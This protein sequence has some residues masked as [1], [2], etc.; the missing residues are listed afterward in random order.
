MWATVT[1]SE[2]LTV[3]A[4]LDANVIRG[5]HTTNTILTLAF[6]GMFDLKWS[7]QATEEALRNR[8]RGMRPSLSK[9]GCS[10]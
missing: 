5:Y 1:H 6:P 8:P 7:A 2:P 3:T 9:P 10:R 4:F